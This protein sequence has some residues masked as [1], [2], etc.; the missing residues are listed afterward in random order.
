MQYM[1]RGTYAFVAGPSYET[2]A[3]C[4]TL[5]LTGSDAV[6]MSTVPEVIVAHHCGMEVCHVM[7]DV[8][9]APSSPLGAGPGRDVDFVR[10][11]PVDCRLWCTGHIVCHMGPSVS[12]GQSTRA[13][14]CR[15]PQV[16]GLS[17]ITN[18]AILDKNNPTVANHEEVRVRPVLASLL[19]GTLAL[20]LRLFL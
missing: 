17:L 18:I 12:A 20:A 7:D 16:I 14:A 8:M 6:G 11:R 5:Q 9:M 10:S 2:P 3:E 13:F 1:R 19:S 4:K 15:T